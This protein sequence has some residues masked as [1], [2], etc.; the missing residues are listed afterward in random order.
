MAF[1]APSL[2][3]HR[4]SLFGKPLETVKSNFFGKWFPL[5]FVVSPQAQGRWAFA[6][7][8]LPPRFG[9]SAFQVPSATFEE[10]H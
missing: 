6:N 7:V 8:S 10:Y 3:V 9:Y 4:A 1:A 2:H 5:H